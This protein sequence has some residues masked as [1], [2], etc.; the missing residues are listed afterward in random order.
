VHIWPV[1]HL[2]SHGIRVVLYPSWSPYRTSHVQ[3]LQVDLISC[4]LH[5]ASSITQR[6]GG[7]GHTL[8]PLPREVKGVICPNTSGNK[9]CRG[10]E[11]LRF[12]G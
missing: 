9:V 6:K 8:A 10:V 1:S 3:S 7:R 4:L 11:Q 12:V 2:C 5:T